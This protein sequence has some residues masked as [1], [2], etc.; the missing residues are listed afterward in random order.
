MTDSSG[1][2]MLADVHH[3]ALPPGYLAALTQVGVTAPVPGVAFPEWSPELSLDAMDRAG[4][5]VAFCSLS[6]PGLAG[7]TGDRASGIARDTNDEL[8]DLVRSHPRL[9]AFA[10]IP[11]HDADAAIAE[12]DH[13]LDVAGL[14]GIGLYTSVAGVYLGDHSLEPLMAHLAARRATVFV[15]P[16]MSA[17]S[18]TFGLP[19]SVLEFPLDTTRAA[20]NLLFSG[21]LDRHPELTIILSHAG[22][23]VP[24][25]ARRMT[26]AATI[27]PDLAGRP[28]VDL[29]GSLRR[30]HYDLAM[31]ATE[32]Q[33]RCLVDL[34]GPEQVLFGSDY[35]FMPAE[36]GVDNANG[37][38]QYDA[39]HQPGLL[40]A[41][42]RNAARLLPRLTAAAV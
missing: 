9:G 4:I 24:Y 22:G 31:S 7:T 2:A 3:H 18:P 25:L 16:T 36:H 14:D 12:V 38:R 23:A 34:V 20:A 40:A 37:L 35:P 8:S 15:H 6:V 10:L 1:T 42:S 17:A 32:S 26:H 5:E 33:I 27:N 30:L 19:S 28:P 21:T 39:D 41:T 13:A 11:V 29:L